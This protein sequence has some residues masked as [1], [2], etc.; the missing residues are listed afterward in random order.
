MKKI[1]YLLIVAALTSCSDFLDESPR[2][3]V[4][5]KSVDDMGFMMDD[6]V[7]N[8]GNE[9]A[10]GTNDNAFFDDDCAIAEW[11][12]PEY[13]EARARKFQWSDEIY[14][15]SQNDELWNKMFK[16]IY[17][18]NWVVENIEDAEEDADQ[19]FTKERVM[20]YAKA[21]RAFTYLLL[22]N[23][24]APFYSENAATD[25]A[26]PMPIDSDVNTRHPKSTVA[27]VYKQIEKDFIESIDGLA[28]KEDYVHRPSKVNVYGA[29]ARMYLMMQD[30]GKVKIYAEK[31]LGIES[32]L[33]DYNTLA[34]SWFLDLMVIGYP[35]NFGQP[36]THPHILWYRANGMLPNTFELTEDLLALFD[37]AKDLRFRYFTTNVNHNNPMDMSA[38]PRSTYLYDNT[39]GISVPELYLMAAE[40]NLRAQDKSVDKANKWI[41][42]L[43]KNRYEDF[44]ST[45]ETNEELLLADI[46]KE[47]RL[48]LRFKGLRWL[49]IKRLKIKKVI[50]HELNGVT[51]TLDT[52][53]DE[54][55]MPIPSNVKKI[56]KNL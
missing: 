51:Y 29:M 28:D 2:G 30:Y 10:Q 5:P 17:T 1:L 49:D 50:T 41:N 11:Q 46:L 33:L 48:E 8:N 52:A 15:E 23:T 6:A 27:E 34:P 32:A 36:H 43:K 35:V 37:Q 9:V 38:G 53:D 12:Q 47:R 26:I 19:V 55:Y 3:K 45:D 24:Y 44:V 54:Y 40:A 14:T 56:N 22:V 21:N 39:A 16:S 18:C 13:T 25:L 4:I 42:E 7:G 20:A 31:A